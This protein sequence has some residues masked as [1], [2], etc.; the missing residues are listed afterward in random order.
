MAKRKY[1][2]EFK[3]LVVKEYLE[4]GDAQSVADRHKI[5]V[6]NVYVWKGRKDSQPAKDQESA[7]KRLQKE[8][9]ESQLENQILREIVKKTSQVFEVGSKKP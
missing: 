6:Q 1:S 9:K 8:L 3:D 2:Q 4:T 5:N 7:I